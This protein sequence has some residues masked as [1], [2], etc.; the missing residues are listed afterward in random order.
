MDAKAIVV[1]HQHGA[2]LSGC[3]NTNPEATVVCLCCSCSSGTAL[4]A[5]M[6][7]GYKPFAT[8]GQFSQVYSSIGANRSTVPVHPGRLNESNALSFKLM[9]F[10][11][12]LVSLRIF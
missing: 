9:T 2:M 7:Y 6:L 12:F 3:E 4:D 11:S 8:G 1:L 10:L 5:S